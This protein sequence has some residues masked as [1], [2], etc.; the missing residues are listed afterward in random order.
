MEVGGAS[1]R[2]SSNVM[3]VGG[4]SSRSSSDEGRRGQH[5]CKFREFHI[6]ATD[7][8]Y[9]GASDA[10]VMVRVSCGVPYSQIQKLAFS[11]TTY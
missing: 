4:A 9:C 8:M 7:C 11:L 5:V 10:R 2:S 3:K 1:S 6:W